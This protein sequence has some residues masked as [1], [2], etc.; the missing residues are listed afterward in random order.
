MAAGISA[1]GREEDFDE[2]ARRRWIVKKNMQLPRPASAT[3]DTPTP[4]PAFA[5][6]DKPGLAEEEFE[7]PVA[8]IPLFP[9]RMADDTPVVAAQ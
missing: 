8:I 6:V 2:R 3:M 7:E 9:V 1:S 4:I 5:P